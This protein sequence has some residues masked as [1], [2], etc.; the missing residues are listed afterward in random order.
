MVVATPEPRIDVFYLLQ[1]S[2]DGML[3]GEDMYQQS[4]APIPE[5]YRSGG[6][7][8]VYPYLPG[9]SVLVLPA[10]ILFGDVRY[11]EIAASWSP[12]SCC[13]GCCRGAFPG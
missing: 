3:H 7:F 2:A 13:A 10:R 5:L 11:A 4:W 12:R 9:T 8:A 6:L 1:G